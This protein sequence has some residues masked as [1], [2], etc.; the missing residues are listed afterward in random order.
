M[1]ITGT[2]TGG[3]RQSANISVYVNV[4]VPRVQTRSAVLRCDISHLGIFHIPP[5]FDRLNSVTLKN[6]G[7]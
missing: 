3:M 7:P 6:Y 1:T 2:G 4:G 5:A